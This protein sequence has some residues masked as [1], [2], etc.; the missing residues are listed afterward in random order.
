VISVDR[1]DDVGSKTGL[2]TPIIGREECL[3][4]ATELALA[5]PEEAD[6]N[7]IFAAVRE[8]DELEAQGYRCEVAV[9]AGLPDRGVEGDQKLRSEVAEALRRHAAEG[10]VLVADGPEDEEVVPLI[11]SLAPVVS[12]RRVVIRHS[13]SVEMS[14]LILGRYLK[15]L[16]FDPRYSR[17]F[18]GVPGLVLFVF[19]VLILLG[20]SQQAVAISLGIIGIAFIVRGFEL[21]RLLSSVMA[22]RLS[23]LL[24]LFAALG[25][26][27]IVAAGVY[28][29]TIAVGSAPEYS[30]VVEDP[31][32]FLKYG[33][34]FFGIFIEHALN[35]VWVG[36]GLYLGAKALM[37]WF[38]RSPKMVR[39]LLGLLVLGLL[40]LP[41][42][43]FSLIL[44]GTGRVG[45]L[46][47]F[48][49]IGL[50]IAILVVTVAYQYIYT[51]LRTPGEERAEEE[52]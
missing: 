14:Y 30:Q 44:Q 26:T 27:M 40:Y 46:V 8:R 16:A 13:R 21:D 5:D 28:Q 37:Y 45:T 18:L 25:G 4:A 42:L 36:V 31:S 29:A 11:Q 47:S 1:D 39:N 22:L 19:S 49:L 9:V 41:V 6:A 52:L 20:Y 3:R 38:E 50:S 7:A 12:I 34:Y 23:G 35:L 43:E 51:R 15:M 17:F 2:S 48:L 10:L 33:A 32:L 24:R